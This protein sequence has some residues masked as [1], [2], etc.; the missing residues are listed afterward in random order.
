MSRMVTVGFDGSRESLAAAQWAA[1]EAVSR[2]VPMRL[3]EAWDCED[4]A[5]SRRVDPETARGWGERSLHMVERRLRRRHPGLQVE[6]TWVREDPVGAL[7]AAG[8]E[9][10]LL[11]LGS[12]GLSGLRG[13]LAGSVASAVLA[14]VQRP[15][16]LV[17]AP[18]APAPQGND[19]AG[20]IVLGLDLARPSAE[21]LEFAFTGA[22][23]AGCGVRVLYS[24]AIP[25]VHG[26]DLGGAFRLLSARLKDEWSQALDSA[27]APWTSK[28]PGVRVVRQCR[29]GRAAQDL[30]E[31]AAGAR[32]VV[33]GRKDRQTGAGRHLGAVA[34]AVIHHSPA[35]VAVVPHP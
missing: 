8:N 24:W 34:H 10:D 12:R 3:L 15:T 28:Y 1:G 6:S 23:R 32:L 5:H 14:R 33:V 7:C 26:P 13:F 35:P 27:L 16:V 25:T 4:S 9:S 29:Q 30:L 19:T 31:A 22:D 2:A 21:M 17:R 11:V 20:S 18:E